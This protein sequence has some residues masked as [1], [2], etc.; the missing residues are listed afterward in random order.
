MAAIRQ[1]ILFAIVPDELRGRLSAVHIMVVTGGPP[2]GDMVSGAMGEAFG[3]RTS[4]LVGGLSVI[5]GMVILARR[6]PEF[7]QW[8]DPDRVPATGVG[9]PSPEPA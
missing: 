5:G 8:R 3:V 4:S 6:V 7:A 9:T 1:T 2:V